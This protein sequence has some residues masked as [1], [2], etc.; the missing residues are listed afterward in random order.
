MTTPVTSSA[1]GD[2]EAVTSWKK[3]SRRHGSDD[4][5]YGSRTVT[6]RGKLFRSCT[7]TFTMT[8]IHHSEG[9]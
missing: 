2:R 8:E 9:E 6:K 5:M 7:V 3:V 4:L 1:Q